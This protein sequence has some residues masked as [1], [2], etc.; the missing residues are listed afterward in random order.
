V[1]FLDVLETLF[2]RLVSW[3][4]IRVI[5]TRQPAIRF[6]DLFLGGPSRHAKRFVIVV[7]GSHKQTSRVARADLF[8]PGKKREYY[9]FSS[10]STN[11]A[12]TTLSLLSC[13]VPAPSPA[14]PV[15]S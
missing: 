13:S 3:I 12:S 8:H 15:P 4:Q 7:S 6:P 11:S 5:F 1:S 2:G 14:A 9:F 10:T